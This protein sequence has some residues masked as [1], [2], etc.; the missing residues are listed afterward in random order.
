[1]SKPIS[2]RKLAA[3]R[4]NAAK[5][6]GPRT[7]KGK[8]ASSGNATKHAFRSR[9]FNY[10]PEERPEFEALR[11]ALLREMQP[12]GPLESEHFSHVLLTAW[13]LRC[14]DAHEADLLAPKPETPYRN[15]FTDPATQHG[16]A[17]INRYRA[18]LKRELARSAREIERLQT[19]RASLYLSHPATALEV[20]GRSPCAD[21]LKLAKQTQT[22]D[23]TFEAADRNNLSPHLLEAPSIA[24]RLEPTLARLNPTRLSTIQ[25][26]AV[27][28]FADLLCR[29][30]DS[31]DPGPPTIEFR[32][33]VEPK[34]PDMKK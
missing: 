33:S 5:S 13:N 28:D 4:A 21:P 7:S 6:T 19:K 15:P 10:T 14:L 22:A 25:T 27:L 8:A 31:R 3:N 12:S 23:R 11:D 24:Q 18:D 20:S 30:R 17:I 29:S 16:L 1:M 26:H 32:T 34:H 9:K 2:D